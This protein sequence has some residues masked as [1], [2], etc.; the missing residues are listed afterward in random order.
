M[1]LDRLEFLW[2]F[3]LLLIT[4]VCTSIDFYQDR[5]TTYSSRISETVH[6]HEQEYSANA[7]GD[8]G[9]VLKLSCGDDLSKKKGQFRQ[10][11]E[12]KIGSV[13]DAVERIDSDVETNDRKGKKSPHYD[14]ED[15]DRNEIYYVQRKTL[16]QDLYDNAVL[17]TDDDDEDDDDDDDGNDSDEEDSDND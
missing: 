6:L 7:V 12:T 10:E 2:K 8:S 3:I 17:Y 14:A 9:C 13:V 11:H 16:H 1:D 4:V 15:D 5:I